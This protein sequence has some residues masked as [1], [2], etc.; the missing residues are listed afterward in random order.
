MRFARCEVSA[1]E[2]APKKK[3]VILSGAIHIG[4]R[5]VKRI[6]GF[7]MTLDQNSAPRHQV[8][9]KEPVPRMLHIPA[10][11]SRATIL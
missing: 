11:S 9:P 3:S 6:C 7:S 8:T 1:K 5:A 10:L 2:E 4:N